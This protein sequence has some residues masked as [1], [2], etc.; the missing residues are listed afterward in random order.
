MQVFVFKQYLIQARSTCR[1]LLLAALLLL[2]SGCSMV[3]L[4][5]DYLDNIAEW[6]A[7]DYFDLEPAQREL[8]SRQFRA[9][10]DWHRREQLP[11]YAQFFT[12]ARTRAQSG[13]QAADI[14][15]L[16]DGIKARYVR[17]AT[18]GAADAAELLAGLSATQI[19]H[20]KR[21]I[22]EANRKFQR[23]H[24]SLGSEVERR[25]A[26]TQ[27]TLKQLRDWTGT[28]SDA[29]EQRITTL[30]ADVPLPDRLR[31]EDRLRRQKEFIALLE[32]RSS[33]RAE[34]TTRL[35]LWLVNWEQG[36]SPAQ[37]RAF[38]DYWRK[39]AQFHAAADSLLTAEQRAHMAQ[40]LQKFSD[41]FR[42]LS[43]LRPSPA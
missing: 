40:R 20:L 13:L 1:P 28:L 14:Q 3:R 30:L 6:V 7:Q 36:R 37:T 26:F 31:H 23:E 8:F 22:D 33:N 15:W 10:H 9:L 35:R 29:Q 2:L 21:E 16:I 12:E 11:E 18:R 5:Y 27:R 4:G 34:F 43:A 39:R 25:N 19:E 17:I 24:R 32:H 42:R 38:E 41:D